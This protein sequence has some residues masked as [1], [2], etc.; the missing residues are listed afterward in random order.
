M[1]RNRRG[2]GTHLRDVL[3]GGSAV[4]AMDLRFTG[5]GFNSR[6]VAFT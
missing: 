6:Q 3:R 1:Y 5:R 4:W 2:I